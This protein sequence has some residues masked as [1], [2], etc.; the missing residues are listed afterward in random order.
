[1]NSS[2]RKRIPVGIIVVSV[3][4][5]LFGLLEIVTAFSHSFFGI[6]TLGT[7]IATLSSA[8]IGAL[9]VLAGLLILTLKKWGFVLAIIFLV[10]DILGRLSLVATGLY[11]LNT[12]ENIYGIISGTGIALIIAVYIYSRRSLF[13]ETKSKHQSSM[14]SA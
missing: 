8:P 1:M 10:L 7:S 4:M 3:I 12:A 9:Y 11:P 14:Q 13:A 6:T 5:I 2:G